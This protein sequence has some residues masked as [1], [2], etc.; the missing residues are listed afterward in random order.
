MI[1]LQPINEILNPVKLRRLKILSVLMLLSAIFS[2]KST[3]FTA[4]NLPEKQLII[5]SQGGVSGFGSEYIFCESGQVFKNSTA[6]KK[7]EEIRIKKK[8][9]VR[10]FFKTAFKQ[11]WM[12]DE[13]QKP[14]NFSSFI[15]FKEKDIQYKFVWA[16]ND[17]LVNPAVKSM[18]HDAKELLNKN[19]EK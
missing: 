3:H 9:E 16:N 15:I 6:N 1:K 2:C 14:G 10:K 19:S 18:V 4:E 17:T 13:Y 11:S 5:G 7:T 8:S 12:K